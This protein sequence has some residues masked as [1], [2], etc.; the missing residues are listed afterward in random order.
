MDSQT[1][2]VVV[3]GAGQSGLAAGQFLKEAGADFSILD[4][5]ARVGDVWRNRWDSLRLF[6]PARYSS[7]PGLKFPAAGGSFPGKDGFADYLE[8]YAAHFQLPVRTGIQVRSVRPVDG[9]FELQASDGEL[10]ARSVI[11]APGANSVPFVPRLAPFLDASILQLHSSEYRSP[12]GLPEGGVTVAGAGTSGMEIALELA[13]HRP[14]GSVYLAGT[15]TRHIP[16]A[17]FRF[18]GPLYWRLVNSLL[19]LDTRPGRKVAAGFHQQGAPLIRVS[20]KDVERAGVARLS[21]LQ[22]VGDVPADVRTIVWATGYRPDFGWI[23]GLPLD[24]DGWP[25]TDRGI[26]PELPGLYFVG[27]PFQYALT[28]GLVG[29]VGRDAKYVVEHLVA[30]QRALSWAQEQ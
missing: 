23:E 25:A 18:T 11:A 28:S 9:G 6:T 16:D 5:A 21:R 4:G 30:H 1:L 8:A 7:L 29:G 20:V 15:P 3:I 19:T 17:V 14:A 13:Q 2:D 26:V 27:M 22:N 24:A 12:S 10:R